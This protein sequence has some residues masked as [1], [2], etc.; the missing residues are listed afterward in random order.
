MIIKEKGNIRL[1]LFIIPALFII[2]LSQAFPLAYS[3]IMS[4]LD[5]ELAKSIK[6]RG[7]I[8][9]ANYV[10]AFNDPIFLNAFKISLIFCVI[11]TTLEIIFGFILA[12]FTIGEKLVMRI[13]RTILILPMV[14]APVVTGTI[15]R[16]ILNTNSGLLNLLLGYIGVQGSNW[17]GE[18]SLA[19]MSVIFIEIWQWT[20]FVF[21]VFSAGFSVIPVEVYEAAKVDGAGRFTILKSIIIPYL[22]PIIFIALLFRVVD[23][24]LVLDSV[25]TTTFGGPGFSTNVITLFIYW[26]SLRYF[27]ISYASAASWI[28]SLLTICIALFL[29]RSQ[30]TIKNRLWGLE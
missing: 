7:F 19:L 5:W 12:Y 25:F 4:L 20:P 16:M 18:P 26:Q 14:I 13:V 17:L 9:F 27:N 1:F 10:R 11:A 23:T 6:P 3:F 8:G 24:L 15:W 21:I 22:I 30:N 29:I 2:L 28:L